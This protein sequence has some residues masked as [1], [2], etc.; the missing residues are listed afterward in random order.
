MKLTKAHRLWLAGAIT[1]VILITVAG[2]VVNKRVAQ[3][4]SNAVATPSSAATPS[5][6][7]TFSNLGIGE[8][9]RTL[10]KG[11]PVSAAVEQVI[12]SG[13]GASQT[14]FA[15]LYRD[16]EGRTRH[17]ELVANGSDVP[18]AEDPLKITINDPAAG[19][20]FIIDPKANSA[21]RKP[22]VAQPESGADEV[23]NLPLGAAP[24]KRRSANSQVLPVPGTMDMGQGLKN[25][26]STSS[27]ETKRESL[28]RR[29]IEGMTADGTRT[30]MTVPAGRMNNEKAIEIGCDRWY[31]SSL[32]T[33]ILIECSDSRYGKSSYRMT[34]IKTEEPAASL[35]T[36]PR[37]YKIHE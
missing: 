7:P 20:S 25:S 8:F 15:K 18:L 4:D 29:Q 22:F 32:K 5:S 10:V 31:S 6:V 33:W 34:Q 14:T 12:T 37:D 9:T 24:A 23:R 28:G 35:F 3:P 2:A 11:L 26:G 30:I 1:L 27:P 21:R 19:V 17:D 16:S 13:D 36:V